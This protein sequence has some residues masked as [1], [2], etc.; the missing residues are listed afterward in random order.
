MN[1]ERILQT[2]PVGM[3]C[4]EGCSG[5]TYWVRLPKVRKHVPERIKRITA[6]RKAKRRR[7][8]LNKMIE[9]CYTGVCLAC[10]GSMVITMLNM[11]ELL[12]F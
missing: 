7:Q 4:I 1:A 11:A 10:I 5:T 2:V 3:G 8:L 12:P 6:Y 9:W